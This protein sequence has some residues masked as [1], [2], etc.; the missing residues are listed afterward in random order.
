VRKDVSVAKSKPEK[1]KATK[2][3]AEQLAKLK[4]LAQPDRWIDETF[5][6]TEIGSFLLKENLIAPNPDKN[7]VKAFIV[8]GEGRQMLKE[9]RDGSR[10]RS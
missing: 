7:S 8:T 9:S 1:P 3:S 4:L 2:L 10:A 6:H 5:D